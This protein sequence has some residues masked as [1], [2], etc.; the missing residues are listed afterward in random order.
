MTA[1]Q[2]WCRRVPVV[3]IVF[4]S[5]S[6]LLERLR[7][8]TV[9]HTGAAVTLTIQG[10]GG[11]GKTTVAAILAEARRH[12]LD[13]VWWVRAEQQAVL[14][15]DLAELARHVGVPNSDDPT[16]TAAAVRDWLETTLRSLVVRGAPLDLRARFPIPLSIRACGFPAHGFPTIFWT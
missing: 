15:A 4:A 3:P 10:M 9:G 12:E 11:V 7:E 16:A 14:I 5:R 2:V 6:V 8:S 1:K 13:I